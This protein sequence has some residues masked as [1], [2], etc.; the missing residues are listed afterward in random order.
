MFI[1]SLQ[2]LPDNLGFVDGESAHRTDKF[3]TVLFIC[4]NEPS[5]AAFVE[6]VSCMALKYLNFVPVLEVH[7]A[8]WTVITK[9][10]FSEKAADNGLARAP[11]RSLETRSGHLAEAKLFFSCCL[12]DDPHALQ[13]AVVL[14][15]SKA[16]LV[17]LEVVVSIFLP[18]DV[19]L[20]DDAVLELGCVYYNAIFIFSQ[21]DEV[22]PAAGVYH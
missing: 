16:D 9:N 12:L 10:C 21:L 13:V 15:L 1:F 11:E 18:F 6:P 14:E 20:G 7:E 22:F 8:N 17:M 3:D 5:I 4:C 2:E 19:V